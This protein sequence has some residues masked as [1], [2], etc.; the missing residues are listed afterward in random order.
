MQQSDNMDSSTLY[1]RYE[2]QLK[3]GLDRSNILT[4]NNDH[5]HDDPSASDS[6]SNTFSR[7]KRTSSLR[8]ELN[9]SGLFFLLNYIEN[10]LI[11]TIDKK[12]F[13]RHD[14]PTITQKRTILDIANQQQ[15]NAIKDL[16]P[17]T[18]S[19]VI[20][21]QLPST[22]RRITVNKCLLTEEILSANIKDLDKDAIGRM[23]SEQDRLL[24]IRLIDHFTR[25]LKL[26]IMSSQTLANKFAP[27]LLPNN[28][29][30]LYDKAKSLLKHIVE[31]IV[32][33]QNSSSDD[34][35][36]TDKKQTV[37]QIIKTNTNSS[38]S[39]WLNK[40]RSGGMMDDDDDDDSSSE[41]AN[42][43]KNVKSMSSAS[44]TPRKNV[45]QDDSDFDFYS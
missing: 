1:K 10:E 2:D 27:T 4:T 20:L 35:T 25:L 34:E 12:K 7:S 22:I 5:Q 13:Y 36:S 37:Q 28:S 6:S 21:D 43:K 8:M 16:D 31:K 24:W 26:H 29:I 32:G 11:D 15:Q 39:S 19:M 40:L 23:L 9:R 33:I 18:A 45:N 42:P 44:T 14:P 3:V 41:T 17:A 38:N 30:Y